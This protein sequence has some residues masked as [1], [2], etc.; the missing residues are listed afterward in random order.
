MLPGGHNIAKGVSTEIFFKCP[1]PLYTNALLRLWFISSKYSEC[2]V[3]HIVS[4][5]QYAVQDLFT[6]YGF[7]RGSSDTFWSI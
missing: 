1:P 2:T 6:N 3:Q 4:C 5:T 7:G